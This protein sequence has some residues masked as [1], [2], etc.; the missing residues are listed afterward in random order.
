MT[1]DLAVVIPCFNEQKNLES[2]VLDEVYQYLARQ[3]F[4]WQVIVV[5]DASTDASR[6]LV[7]AFI[8]D[9]PNFTLLDIPHG[10]KPAAVWA[11]IQN[12][13]GEAIL[14]TD[15]DQSTPIRELDKLLPWYQQGFATVI[16]SRGS[17]REGF[18]IVR[19]LGSMVF[20]GFRGILLLRGISDTQCGFKL[21]RR[22]VLTA[23]FPFLEFFRRKEN[24]GGWKVTAYDVELLYLI[25]RAGYPI[26][27][28]A[29][30]WY[31]RDQSVTKSLA[32][33]ESGRYL[34]ESFEMF[35]EIVRVRINQTRGVYDHVG[36][37]PPSR[38]G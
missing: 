11:G 34:R 18:S 10:G 6:A 15:M 30:E 4:S 28:V 36:K 19:R 35:Q 17:A 5:N 31:N 1:F 13:I 26:K 21:F 9:K 27:E 20:R 32:R 16:G 2:G 7:Q 24:L 3:N 8:Q 29:V 23:I 37:P 38:V 14:L 25:E 33:S 22:D 12:A